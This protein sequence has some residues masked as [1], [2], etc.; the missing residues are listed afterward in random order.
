MMPHW[1]LLS[2]DQVPMRWRE[3]FP[4]GCAGDE[5]ALNDGL[6]GPCHVWVPSQLPDWEEAVARFAAHGAVVCVLAL[7]PQSS[8]A[9]RALA[10]GARGYCHFL[11]PSELL[12][13]VALVTE[14]EGIWM[15]SELLS[16]VVGVSF[17]ALGGRDG[18]QAERLE[19][20][21]ERE[22]AV[23]LAVAEGFSNKEVA[24][25]LDITPRTVKAHLGAIFRKLDVRD[26]M[27]LVLMLSRQ[28]LTSPQH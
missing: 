9:L 20:L 2:P 22:R 3:A 4:E 5:S 8:E 25:R 10:A 13:Q 19:C 6:E 15:G 16:Q 1:I 7:Q 18:V 21:T 14:H 23:A 28:E 11:S 26:R 27:Q 12:K 24:R 17:R